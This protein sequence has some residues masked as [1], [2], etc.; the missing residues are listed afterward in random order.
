[1]GNLP[2][3]RLNSLLPFTYVGVDAPLD[4]GK[5]LLVSV[6]RKSSA[7]LFACLTSRVTDFRSDKGTNFI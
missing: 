1:M 5:L 7:I 2:E 3:C 6:N 4:P